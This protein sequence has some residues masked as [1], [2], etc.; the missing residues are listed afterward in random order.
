MNIE[1]E[2]DKLDEL[3]RLTKDSN[4]MLHSM[5][6]NAW[7]GGIF[8]L[9]I[10]AAFLLIPIWLYMQYLAPVVNQMLK[11]YQHIQGTNAQ[12]QAQFSGIQE[13]LQKFQSMYGGG[14]KSQQ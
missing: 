4:R 13:A 1:Y 7:L 6:R 3:L 10:W 9:V 11:T 2:G 12:A 8:K 14:T 5:R